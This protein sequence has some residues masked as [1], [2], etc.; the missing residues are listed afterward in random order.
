MHLAARS[1]A[2]VVLLAATPVLGQEGAAVPGEIDVDILLNY[3]LQDGEHSPVTG[4]VGTEELDVVAPVVVVRWSPA[5]V[6]TFDAQLGLDQITS[7]STDNMDLGEASV[8]SASRIDTRAYTTLG[9]GRRLGGQDLAWRLGFSNEYDYV[10][11]MAGVDWSRSFRRQ[12]T[13]LSAALRHYEDT[14]DLYG[15]DG[16]N[17]GED[18]RRT[19][20]LDLTWTEVLGRRTVASAEL[21]VSSQSGFLAT[22]FHEVILAS[23]P[24]FPEG[25]RVAERLPDSRLRTALGLRLNHAFSSSYVQRLLLRYYEDDW[26]LTASTLEL[27][28]W[29]RLPTARELWIYPILRYHDQSAADSFGLP[30]TL[31]A[32]DPFVTADRDLSGF[33]SRKLGLGLRL[34]QGGRGGT[35]GRLRF[36]ETRATTYS[37]DDGFESFSISL[38][39]GFRF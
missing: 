26:G 25:E 38:G 8:S 33:T 6:W 7:A 24:D 22:P 35:A 21:S 17:R 31:T 19:T 30:G 27:E 13:T 9:A 3:Y 5:G 18:S 23:S 16:V 36:F 1:V 39:Q 10:S 4:G 37:R 28:P 32:D 34:N 20:D 11:I 29:F 12:N 14:I 2:A 15:I